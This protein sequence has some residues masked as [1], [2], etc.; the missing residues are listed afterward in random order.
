M[1]RGAQ[2][3]ALGE[4]R[5]EGK[6]WLAAGA[7]LPPSLPPAAAGDT[8][9]LPAPSERSAARPQGPRRGGGGCLVSR[10]GCSGSCLDL[11]D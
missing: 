9:V 10:F 7:P 5:E 11:N 3:C 4:G 2:E 1:R 6:G 8:G